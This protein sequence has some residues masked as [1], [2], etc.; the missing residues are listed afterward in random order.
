[1]KILYAL[2]A[3][4][5]LFFTQSL[6]AQ[7]KEV[8]GKITDAK[9][10]SPLPGV[11]IKQK[12][13]TSNTVSLVDGSFK[14]TVSANA[15]VLIFS[16]VGY[17][18][19]EL[20]ISSL[21][22]VGL[23]QASKSLSEVVVVGYGTRI[24]RDVTSSISR[25]TSKEFQNLPL[26]SFES[27]LQGRAAGVFINQGSGKLGQGLNIRVRGISSISASQQPF[28]VIDGI[29]IVS[30]A[31]G[32]ATEN[33]NPLATINPD[34]I[35]S[36]E[37]LKDAASAAI[38]GARASNGVL[39]ITTK[40]G[41]VGKTKVNIG[42][43]TGWSEP[44]KK[45][46]FLNAAQYKELF[47]A[48]ATNSG[49]VAADEFE[50]ETGT[51]DWN[52]TSDVNWADEAFQKGK[53]AQYTVSISGGDAKTKF[54][55][56][57]SW[58][59]QTGI[60]LG[61]RLDRG[62]G[63]INLDHSISSRIKIGLNVSL[64]KSRNY[65]V[66][67]DNAFTNPLQLNAL[68]PIQPKFGT[69]GKLN[70]ATIYYNNLIDQESATDIATTFRSISSAYGELILTPDLTFRSQAG[71][72]FN[73]LQEDQFL[74]K[75]T[76]DGAPTGQAFNNQVTA[77]VLTTTNTLNYKKSFGENHAFDALAGTE[78]QT[79]KTS[80]GSVT[81]IGFPS[82]RF[83]KIA[84]AAI[85]QAG[86]STETRFAFLSYFAKANYKFMDRYLVGASFRVDGSSRFGKN[87]RYGSF[88]ALSVG[89]IVSEEKFL[90]NSNNISFLKLRGSY[91]RTGN[92]E[93]GNFSS[94]S[95]FGASAYA[96]IAGL[97]ATQIGIPDL[98]WEKTDQFDVGLDFGF[99]NNRL[100]GEVD[101]FS[102][103]TN[104]LLLSVPLPSANG[105]TSITKNIGDM[106]NKGWEVVLNGN[107]LTGD[108]KWT[109]SVNVSTY[110]NKITRLVIPVPPGTRTMG[111]L[112][113]GQPFGQFF[114]LSYAGVDP[115]NGDALYFKNDK[116]TTN[117]PSEATDTIVGNPNPDYYGGFNNRFSYKGFDLDIQCQFVKGGDIYNM[118]G[119]FQSVNGDY[120]DN[121]TVDQ[122]N[123]WKKAGD[124]T[125]VPQP[126]LYGGNGSIKSSRW[127]QDGSYFR[128]KSIN[129]GY[130]FPRKLIN[131]FRL[132]NARVYVA[133]TNL[134]TLTKYKGYDPEVN[135][136]FVGTLNLGHD[137]YTPPQARTISVGINVGF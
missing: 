51:T 67:S 88:P 39:L 84:S 134:V 56:S 17:T 103:K 121:Q 55:I 86:S 109:A 10:G 99:F 28:V 137:F 43:F 34:D 19:Q 5:L 116:T 63:R 48:A 33:D 69:N 112:A 72:D 52:G 132:E 57:G 120:F 107:I 118:A 44:T 71:I 49:L 15:T 74:G 20:P 7:T 25:V 92:A 59:D 50:G 46:K 4:V 68:P 38:Y 125:A 3:V 64:S 83:T 61:N 45:Q 110:E 91:G 11:T 13:G 47:D 40:S 21:M 122:L 79:G 77:T 93:I 78:F 53:I 89:W 85:I 123:Y 8:I 96:D 42:Y 100:T 35:E 2:C 136:G 32:S 133:G 117:D 65:R 127:V 18:D 111:R 1:M 36:I 124:I 26:P 90:K 130:N 81:G 119:F 87:N 98:S 113:V 62:N 60:I 102:K 129:F 6:K 101:Y 31:L 9:D 70:A 76:L 12:G 106:E 30:Q 41:K 131:K 24:K 66:P 27:A 22:N 108:F 126:R 105:F 80:G 115:A 95:L 135:S 37:I 54:L 82:N 128:L 94:L 75:E 97:I 73:N 104:D 58:N 114:G 23:A 16:Y 14:L 29:P